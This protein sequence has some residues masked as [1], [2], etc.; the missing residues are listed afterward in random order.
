MTEPPTGWTTPG[1]QPPP[2]VPQWTAPPSYGNQTPWAATDPTW[3]MAPQPGVIPLRP[4]GLGEI[5]DAAI[6]I[7]RRY[8]K[9]TLGLSAAIALVV[10]VINVLFVLLLDSGT[11]P[12]FGSGSSDSS[13]AVSFNDTNLSSA[14]GSIVTFLAG[15]VLTGVLVAVVGKAV[16]G[17]PA[18]PA[19]IWRSVKGRLWALLGLSLLTGLI[20]ALPIGVGVLIGVVTGSVGLAVLLGLTGGIASVYL[21]VRLALAAPAL[22]LEK[23]SVTTALKRSGVLVKGAWWRTLGIL[24]L[25]SVIV[26]FISGIVTVPIAIAVLIGSGGDPTG[27]PLQ[28]VT[29]VLTGLLSIFI[30]PFGAGVRAMVYVDRRMRAEGL[31]VALQSAATTPPAL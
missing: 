13:T 5:L 10:T 21:Y 17:Q 19:E 4:L 30:A 8:P 25:S 7:I 31:D 26:A 9:P 2:E 20:L 12:T 22:V 16:L 15:L 18:P 23:A 29:H 1:S 14:P 3:A 6:K 27:T 28:L 11:R 24:L